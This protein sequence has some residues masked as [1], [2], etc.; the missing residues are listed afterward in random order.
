MNRLFRFDEALRTQRGARFLAGIDEVG[1][2]PLAGPVVAAAVVL[3]FPF[4]P[5]L[6][7]VRDSK[8]LTAQSRER[9]F[10]P[11]RRACV[12]SA[13]GWALPNEIDRHNILQASFLAMRRAF[14]RLNIDPADVLVVVDGPHAVPG[15]ACGQK[16]VIG[17]DRHSLS[18]ACA[19]IIAKVVRDRWMERLD[20]RYPGYGFFKHKGY[21]TAEHLEAL[22]R[23]GP[24]PVHRRSFEPV[25][26]SK[27]L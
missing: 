26:Q 18:V 16:P 20:R 10:E 11:I 15:L 2:G 25:A 14:D 19:S 22:G 24:S 13:V 5:L 6:K 12:R 4:S 17:G 3:K 21:G 27:L 7:S 1:R 23:L 8:A 9:L